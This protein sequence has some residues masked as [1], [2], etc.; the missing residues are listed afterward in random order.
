[1]T[2]LLQTQRKTAV[3]GA[4]PERLAAL[5]SGRSAL[6]LNEPLAKKTTLRVG[7]SADAYAEPA[8]EDE[9]AGVLAF[10]EAENIPWTVLGRGSNLLIR[11]RGIRGVVLGLVHEI[12]CS[13]RVESANI[14]CGAGVKLKTLAGCARQ[15]GLAG[16]EFLEGIPGSVGGALRMNAGAMG[17]AIFD[18]VESVRY[19]D[20]LSRV[21]VA[22]PTQLQPA[23]RG[24]AALARAV[25]VGARFAG[26]PGDPKQIRETMDRFSRKRW[27][28]QPAAPSAGCIFKNPPE[29]S[30]GRLIEELGLKGMRQ[31]GAMIS[32][33]H[34]NFFVNA[35]NATA[36]DFLSLIEM[37]R[38]KALRERGIHLETE[39][40]I[41]GE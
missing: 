2:S 39:V 7:G 28:S 13:V 6:R 10:C 32:L 37:V 18:R 34:G 8:S 21:Q 30:A 17:G 11:D 19:V 41:I 9:L 38:E 24:C 35:G 20:A 5:L 25:V 36:R 1:M 27:Q 23:Y 22:T 3:P 29:T 4:W 40:Q 15:S 31:G 16:F 12:F 33:E 14:D 26:M